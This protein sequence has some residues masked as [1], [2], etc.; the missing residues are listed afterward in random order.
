MTRREALVN[1][2]KM[3]YSAYSSL[4][5]AIFRQDNQVWM[6]ALGENGYLHAPGDAKYVSLFP[7]ILSVP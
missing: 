3:R 5:S 6:I 1:P 2:F 4:K 7:R